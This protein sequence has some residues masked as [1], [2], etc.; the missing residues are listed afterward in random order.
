M[1]WCL[2]SRLYGPFACPAVS[3]KRNTLT[4]KRKRVIMAEKMGVCILRIYKYGVGARGSGVRCGDVGDRKKQSDSWYESHLFLFSLSA[5]AVQK[6]QPS[7]AFVS[8]IETFCDKNLLLRKTND[9]EIKQRTQL[10]SQPTTHAVTMYS[11][12]C[13]DVAE[14]QHTVGTF[15][16]ILWQRELLA[17]HINSFPSHLITS[18]LSLIFFFFFLAG[19]YWNVSPFHILHI[20]FS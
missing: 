8:E 15:K 19:L 9:W 3:N 11:T 6:S 2:Y 1:F 16:I 13:V 12:Y 5:S 17:V 7:C 14:T 20:H 18:L 10:Q 4:L